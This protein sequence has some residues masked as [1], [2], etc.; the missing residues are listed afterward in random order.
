MFSMGAVSFDYRLNS[1][2]SILTQRHIHA[3]A[4]HAN[5]I[6]G[7]HEKYNRLNATGLWLAEDRPHD[8]DYQGRCKQFHPEF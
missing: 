2:K 8:A 3:V 5:C 6:S 1:L 7:A 4:I